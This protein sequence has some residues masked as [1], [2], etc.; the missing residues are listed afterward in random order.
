MTKASIIHIMHTFYSDF[1]ALR[2]VAF[3]QFWQLSDNSLKPGGTFR[4]FGYTIFEKGHQLT[5]HELSNHHPS[6]PSYYLFIYLHPS[7][8]LPYIYYI[9]YLYPPPI[10][11]NLPY[12]PPL[13]FPLHSQ[14]P[15]PNH[16]FLL[17]FRTFFTS[18][19]PVSIDNIPNFSQSP[20]H[21]FIF[22]HAPLLIST[23]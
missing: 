11:P 18:T 23:I 6:H 12:L 15:S 8:H 4:Q 5:N 16:H 19:F 21:P 17:Y 13:Y 20:F 3:P 22:S 1:P 9:I 10:P 14:F 7:L 2:H